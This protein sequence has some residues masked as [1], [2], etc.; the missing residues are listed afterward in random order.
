MTQTVSAPLAV[1]PTAITSSSGETTP[2]SAA[3]SVH[4][5]ATFNPTDTTL[6]SASAT[7]SVLEPPPTFA[8]R[9]NARSRPER[10]CV[11]VTIVTPELSSLLAASLE[12]SHSPGLE[13]PT[14]WVTT[15][16]LTPVPWKTRWKSSAVFQWYSRQAPS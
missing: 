5:T 3:M 16:R 2:W 6:R 10:A 14:T 7:A 8:D 13:K 1:P 11:P 4:S 15:T 9:E 12:N